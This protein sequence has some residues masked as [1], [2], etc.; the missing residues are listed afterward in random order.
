MEKHHKV[1]LSHFAWNPLQEI[2]DEQAA[3]K[4]LKRIEYIYLFDLSLA[5][6]EI[7]QFPAQF[8]W[9][10]KIDDDGEDSAEG[11]NGNSAEGGYEDSGKDSAEDNTEDDDEDNG[12]DGTEDNAEDSG[13]DGTEHNAEDSGE[14]SAKDYGED[15]DDESDEEEPN[16]CL[17]SSTRLRKQIERF[18]R[19]RSKIFGA[20]DRSLKKH[21]IMNLIK[22]HENATGTTYEPIC[23]ESFSKWTENLYYKHSRTAEKYQYCAHW[24]LTS[25]L[26]HISDTFSSTLKTGNS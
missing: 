4:V 11:G 14:D 17:Q 16:W 6:S 5:S 15:D 12:K 25:I 26:A 22:E 23:L 9:A 2:A 7:M 8:S 18:L 1:E 20:N 10:P 13:E 19:N 24:S 21:E 3:R